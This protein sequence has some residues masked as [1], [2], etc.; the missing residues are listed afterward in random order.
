MKKKMEMV[1]LALLF[2]GTLATAQ[3]A[4]EDLVHP[5]DG[6]AKEGQTYPAVGVPFGMVNWTP[7]TRAGETKC[8]APYYFDDERIQG[9]RASH[10]LSGSCVPDYGSITLMPGSG[11]LHTGAV[12]R[13]SRF[14]RASEHATPYVYRVDLKDANAVAEVTGTSRAGIVRFHIL[15]NT[16]DAWVVL[17]NN[18]RAGEGWVKVNTAAREA[19]AEVP[20]RREYAESG[21]PAGFSAWYVVKFD[22]A[23]RSCGTYIGDVQT[24]GETEQVGDGEPAKVIVQRK[25][26]TSTG[27]ASAAAMTEPKNAPRPGFGIY[28]QFGPMRRGDVITFRVGTSFVSLEEAR[29]NLTAEIPDWDFARVEAQARGSWHARLSQIQVAGSDAARSI[30][31]TALYHALLQPRT[32]SDVSG[33]YPR[34]DQ[35]G[36]TAAQSAV[37]HTAK[38]A[39]QY[40]DFSVWD[41]FRAQMPLLT[42]LD[43]K[44]EGEM[45]Q[46][47]V[48]KGE[49]GGFLPIFPAWN[50]YTSEMVGDH[51][52]VMIAD[53]W[54]KGI[55]NFD[56]A[57]AYPLIRKNAL[58]EPAERSDYIDGKGRRGLKPYLRYGYIPLEDHIPEAFHKDEQVSRTLEYAYDDAMIGRLAASL[59]HAEDAVTFK[60]R[61]ENWRN[62]FDAKTG[63]VRGRYEDGT[64]V[65]PFDPRRHVFWITEG[66]PWQYSFFVPQDVP[67]LI[68]AMGGNAAFT[69][70]LDEFFSKGYDDHGNEPGHHTPYLFAAAGHLE[71]TQKVVRGIEDSQYLDAPD[72]LAGNDDAG[73]MSAWYV[74]SAMGFYQICPGVP[75]FTLGSPRF[76]DM[77]VRLPGGKKLHITAVGAEKGAWESESVTFNGKPITDARITYKQI[78]AGGELVFRMK[79]LGGAAAR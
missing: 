21:K 54:S 29:K 9:I 49:Q 25:M 15:Q 11:V 1:L 42:I 5:L 41:I 26:M 79:P 22:H 16:P 13:S 72:G 3:M 34:F 53:A 2:S 33:T 36:S 39:A 23:A 64:W 70:R 27:G 71:K 68:A 65:M 32:Q 59:G 37:E 46:S 48:L 18:A 17:E 63:F 50:S 73:Q 4:V 44:L 55:R 31:Y 60:K 76:D 58:E 38:G 12:A 51:A 35:H 78:M 62:V 45:V 28:L 20:V 75:V 66:T 8:I 10:F 19:T 52:A 30:F 61:G 74:L 47:I 7:Q 43:P 69:A 14:D 57:K 6:T 40:D 24:P 56:M 67:G 77:T